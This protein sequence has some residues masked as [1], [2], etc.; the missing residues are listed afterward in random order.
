MKVK[1]LTLSWIEKNEHTEGTTC[2]NALIYM[3]GYGRGKLTK[4][5]LYWFIDDSNRSISFI[6]IY[7]SLFIII[8]II[9]DI[10][11]IIILH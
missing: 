7:Y 9:I 5:L 11:I 6:F 8:V 10:I 3:N 1:Y 2:D 4:G